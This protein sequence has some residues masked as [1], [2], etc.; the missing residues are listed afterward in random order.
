MSSGDFVGITFRGKP[1]S[2]QH[3]DV[4]YGDKLSGMLSIKRGS[5]HIIFIDDYE[6]ENYTMYLGH[7][8]NLILLLPIILRLAGFDYSVRYDTDHLYAICVEK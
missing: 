1:T 5:T 7:N 8:I 2:I 4:L 3:G 6:R